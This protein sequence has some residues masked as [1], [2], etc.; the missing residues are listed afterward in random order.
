MTVSVPSP[1]S[2]AS[3]SFK[4]FAVVEASK[5]SLPLPPVNSFTPVVSVKPCEVAELP[6]LFT[7]ITELERAVEFESKT[8]TLIPSIPSTTESDDA[9]TS[10]VVEVPPAAI[11]AVPESTSISEAPALSTVAPFESPITVQEKYVSADTA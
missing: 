8:L 11:V 3:K 10:N 7:N 2:I 1:P 5:L 9:V 4:L 6:E